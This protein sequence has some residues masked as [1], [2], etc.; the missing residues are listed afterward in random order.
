MEFIDAKQAV[1]LVAGADRRDRKE[2]EDLA[3]QRLHFLVDYA[4]ERSTYL[5]EKYEDLPENYSLADIPISTRE[6]LTQQFDRWVCDPE[7]TT[8]KWMN[9]L[10]ISRTCSPFLRKYWVIST[11]GTTASHLVSFVTADT[12]PFMMH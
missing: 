9:M 10:L 12:L 3:R 6:E 5:K 2:I 7:I 11:S 4:R 1:A 8:E